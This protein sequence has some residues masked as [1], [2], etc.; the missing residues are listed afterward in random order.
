[1]AWINCKWGYVYIYAYHYTL[2]PW[3]PSCVDQRNMCIIPGEIISPYDL[4]LSWWLNS[5]KVSWASSDIRQLNIKWTNV[6]R[7]EMVLKLLV[8]SQFS[9]LTWV[10]ARESFIHILVSLLTD[11]SNILNSH[12]YPLLHVG[13]SETWRTTASHPLQPVSKQYADI[14]LCQFGTQ[15]GGHGSYSRIPQLLLLVSY[16]EPVPT[17]LSISFGN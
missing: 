7:R 10:L 5:V 12:T 4:K 3:M 8:H 9:H 17:D 15:K 13:W 2:R 11:I 16:L 6:L 14:L 1:M